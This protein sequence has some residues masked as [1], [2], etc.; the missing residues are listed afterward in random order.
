MTTP[1]EANAPQNKD[2]RGS[3]ELRALVDHNVGVEEF[4]TGINSIKCN[5]ATQN[6]GAK[7]KSFA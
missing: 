5:D 4:S 3:T 6:R 1:I 7:H 2:S